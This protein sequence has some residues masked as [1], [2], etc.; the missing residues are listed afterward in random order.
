MKEITA[1]KDGIKY[2]FCT[3]SKKF[4]PDTDYIIMSVL[5]SS[6]DADNILKWILAQPERFKDFTEI[7]IEVLN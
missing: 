5:T 4:K 1:M 2:Y 3:S 7:K 6:E